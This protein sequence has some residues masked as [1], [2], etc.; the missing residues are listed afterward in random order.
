MK[1]PPLLPAVQRQNRHVQIQYDQLRRLRV[2]FQEHL[3]QQCVK[4]LPLA[5]N[6]LVPAGLLASLFQPAQG[7]LARHGTCPASRW[8]LSTPSSES[9]RNSS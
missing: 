7:V 5:V 9:R 1:E 4:R 6:L 3:H 2:R 8:P